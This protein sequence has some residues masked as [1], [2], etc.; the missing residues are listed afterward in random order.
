MLGT[1]MVLE[2]DKMVHMSSNRSSLLSNL[3]HG[4]TAEGGGVYSPAAVPE[5]SVSPPAAAIPPVAETPSTPAP[6]P[7]GGAEHNATL[8]QWTFTKYAADLMHLEPRQHS[9]A[10]WVPFFPSFLPLFAPSC[11]GNFVLSQ[12]FLR[13]PLHPYG[14]CNAVSIPNGTILIGSPIR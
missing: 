2:L 5:A 11:C 14:S 10:A 1:N 9:K 6:P 8:Y 13:T 3:C 7:P 12:P 4:S